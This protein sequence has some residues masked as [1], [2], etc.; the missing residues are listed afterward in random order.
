MD[1]GIYFSETAIELQDVEQKLN[2]IKA[3]LITTKVFQK[4][5]DVNSSTAYQGFFNASE[6]FGELDI[7]V[8]PVVIVIVNDDSSLKVALYVDEQEVKSDIIDLP[9][10]TGSVVFEYK[11][12]YFKLLRLSGKGDMKVI[13][14]AGVIGLLNQ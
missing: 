12:S 11:N 8:D 7:V 10:D 13:I 1:G 6:E 3:N 5:Y 9:K 2:D 4:E 14:R